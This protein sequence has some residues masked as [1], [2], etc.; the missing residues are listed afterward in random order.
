[1]QHEQTLEIMTDVNSID[2]VKTVYAHFRDLDTYYQ[3]PQDV[4]LFGLDSADTMSVQDCC[5]RRRLLPSDG[6]AQASQEV[7]NSKLMKF[8]WDPTK[9]AT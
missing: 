3:L 4:I 7:Y 8:E 6:L 9:A 1:V 5:Q 2:Q